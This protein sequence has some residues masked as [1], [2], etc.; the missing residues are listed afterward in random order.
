MDKIAAMRYGKALFEL[1]LES[2]QLEEYNAAAMGLVNLLESDEHFYKMVSHPGIPSDEKVGFVEATLKGKVP[3]DFIG[4]IVLLLRR[5][6][7]DNMHTL[8]MHFNTLYLD[9]TKQANGLLLSATQ[10]SESKVEEITK[11]ISQKIDKK[12]TLE[13]VVNP[14]LLA[15]FRVEIDGLVFD[16]SAKGQLNNLKK[17]LLA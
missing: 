2:S 14:E 3:E 15:G 10:L 8:F 17:E 16:S 12:A 5:G 4:L 13:V 11:I 1:A 7:E 6:R 9:F